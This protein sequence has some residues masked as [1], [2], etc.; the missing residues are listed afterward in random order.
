MVEVEKV[1]CTHNSL[2]N[3][4]G[5]AI[6]IDHRIM[7][8]QHTPS[9]PLNRTWVVERPVVSHANKTNSVTLNHFPYGPP[10]LSICHQRAVHKRKKAR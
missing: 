4:K 3:I 1:I 5:E 9:S 8:Q 2:L 6:D 10:H 7:K